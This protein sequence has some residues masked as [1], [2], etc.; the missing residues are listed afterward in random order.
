MQGVSFEI[1]GMTQSRVVTQSQL[2]GTKRSNGGAVVVL[3]VLFAV[4]L[5]IGAIR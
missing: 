4:G 2:P 5:L 3:A 1:P